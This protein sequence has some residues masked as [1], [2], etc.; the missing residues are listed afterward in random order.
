MSLM[1]RA[2]QDEQAYLEGCEEGHPDFGLDRVLRVLVEENDIEIYYNDDE[3]LQKKLREM[4]VADA[5]IWRICLMTKVPGFVQLLEGEEIEQRDLDRYVQNAV[6]ETGL[7]R[8][9]VM[10][11]TGMIVASAGMAFDYSATYHTV[12][13]I[14]RERAFI[15]PPSV[16]KRELNNFRQQFEQAAASSSLDSLDCTGLDALVATGLPKAKYY[17]GYYL[18]HSAQLE[19]EG[20]DASRAA[21]VELLQEAAEAGNADAAAELG[22][23]YFEQGTAYWSRAFAYYTGF[24]ALALDQPRR[25]AVARILRQKQSNRRIFLLSAAL[26]LAMLMALIFV[27]GEAAVFF[28]CLLGTICT[29][30]NL[31]ILALAGWRVHR[32]PYTGLHYVPACMFGVWAVCMAI[33]ML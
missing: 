1:D 26:P 5:D 24:G 3:Q 32:D 29:G 19:K 27:P 25:E 18:L 7:N 17:K 6:R 23:F 8:M 28:R 4:N 20:G 31:L 11:L 10:D 22:D 13:P 9:T 14:I 16:Y 33:L 12:R 21:A 15:I 30:C 2:R